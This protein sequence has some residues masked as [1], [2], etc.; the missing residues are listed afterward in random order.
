MVVVRLW[1]TVHMFGVAKASGL[2]RDQNASVRAT[3]TSSMARRENDFRREKGTKREM[4][5]MGNYVLHILLRIFQ[6]KDNNFYLLFRR[7][8]VELRG[9]SVGNGLRRSGQ[10]P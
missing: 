2:L 8:K 10:S 5:F 7:L 1:Q 4:V 9:R 3:I 6:G